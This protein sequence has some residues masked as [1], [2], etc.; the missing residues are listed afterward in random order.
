MRRGLRSLVADVATFAWLDGVHGNEWIGL[1]IDDD[2]ASLRLSGDPREPVALSARRVRI[3]RT[4]RSR[5]NSRRHQQKSVDR[6]QRLPAAHGSPLAHCSSKV[7]SSQWA[8]PVHSWPDPEGLQCP[9]QHV[10]TQVLNPTSRA[11]PFT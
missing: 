6:P 4:Q 7:H 2:A 5:R 3:R 8:R 10:T 11:V 1:A 9:E